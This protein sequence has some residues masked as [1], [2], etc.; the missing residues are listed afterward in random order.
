MKKNYLSLILLL[1]AL[2]FSFGQSDVVISQYI[3]TNSGTTPK[4]IEIFNISGA[5]IDFAV[6]NLEIFQGTNGAAC[7]SLINVTSGTL[8]ADEVWVIGTSNLTS[9][10][11][12][13]GTDLSGTTDYAFAF[14]GDDAL[15][16]EL[17]G[18]VQDMFGIC[19]AD[20]GAAWTGGGVSTANNNLQIQNGICDGDTDGWTDPSSRFDQI[21]DGS[22]MTGF[23]N[24]PASCSTTNTTVQFTST[25]STLPEGGLFIDVCASITNPS[26]TV[27]TTVDITLDG[28]STATNGT[29][30][31]DGAGTPAA[32]VFPQTLTF[33]VGSSADQCLTIYISNDDLLIEGNE[34]VVL[35]LTNPT[36]GDAAALG[37]DTQ[38]VLTITDNDAA[39]PADV[40]ITEIM[41][42]SAGADDE[43]IEICNVSG[44][45]QVLNSYT[46]DYNGSPIF[47]FPATGVII[48][49]GSCITVSLGSNGDGT[50]NNLCPFTPDYGIDAFTNNTNNLSNASGTLSLVASDGI[51]TIDNV[52][53]DDGDGADNTGESLHIVDTSVD[54]SVTNTNWWEVL[55]GGS[56]GVN[57]LISPCT[58]PGPEI[59]VEGTTANFPDIADGDT[60]PAPFDGT[61]FGNVP[62][63]G[64]STNTFRIENFG[65]TQNLTITSVTVLSGD[66]GD[67]SI[68]ALP[69]SPIAPA[70]P[71]G[72]SNFDIEFSPTTIGV[73]TAVIQI[74]SNDADEDP[75]TFTVE[76]NAEC[77]ANTITISP[78]SGP[79][80]TVVT[81][82]GTNLSTATASFNGL[83][84]SVNNI[85]A[86]LMEVTVPPGAISGN[87]EI[88]DDLGCPGSTPF[89]IISSQ[90]SSCEGSSGTTPTDLFISEVTDANTGG[91]TY[92]EIFNGTGVA[93]NLDNYSIQFFNNGNATQNGGLINLNNVNLASGST[94]IVGVSAGSTCTGITGSDGSLADQT[95]F[96]GVNFG[97]N[98]DD[99]I[100]LY[101]GTTHVDSW[102]TYLSNT[103]ADTLGIGSEGVVFTRNNN[104]PNLP[105]TTFNITDWSYVD[106]ASCADN[107]YS[108][109]G[110]YDF[111]TGTPPT[112]N[113]ITCTTTA[114]NEVTISVSATEGFV[115]GNALAYFW[116][117][118]DPL[119]A[120]L[121][122]QAINNGGIYTTNPSSPN[123]IISN[124]NSVLDF[125]FYC[126]VRE[127]NATCYSASNAIQIT[128]GT[129]TWDGTNWIWNDST[130]IDTMPTTMSN[131][132]IDGDYDTAVG[133]IQTSFEACDCV[134]NTSYELNIRNNTY[135]LVEND[136][137]VNGNV[138]LETDGAFVQINDTASVSGDVL[139]D[140]TK[141]SV[142]KETAPLASHLEY[143]Y[144]S[145]PVNGELISDGLFEAN[146]NRIFSFDGQN[147]RDSTRETNNN[148]ATLLGQD[149]IDD[150]ANDWQF[151][152]GAT[153]MLPGVGYASTH[154]PIG[155]IGPNQYIYTFEGPFN[156]GIYNIPI[157][158]NDAELNDNN[159][160]FI[161]NPYPS[162]IDADLF[163]AANASVDQTIGATNGA[164]FFWS[165]N[166]AADGNTNGNENLNYAQSDYAIINGS[167][168]TA[169]GD[170][171][172]PTRFIPSGQGFFVSMDDGV[173]ASVHSGF[174]MTTN[175]V[176]NNSMR[177]T[178]NNNQFFRTAQ[179]NKLWLNLTSDNGVFNQVLVAYVDGAT[180]G[181]DGMYYD[182][183]K[184]LS[185][186]LYSGIYTTLDSSNDK[187]FAI[188][189]KNPNS[190]NIDEVIPLGFSTSIEEA[191]IYTISIYTTEGDF[192][193]ENDIFIIDYDL[194]IIHNLKTADYNFTANKGE[195][196]NRFEI[197]FTSEALSVNDNT[198]TSNDLII[199][200]LN[201]GEVQ[202][203]VNASYIIENVEILDVLG[204]RIYNLVG[205]NSIEVYNLSKL[206]K[207]AYIAR[208]T[209]SNG[210]VI[211]K[212]AIK[213]Q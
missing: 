22:T 202:I 82:S 7:N 119:N 108:D 213:Q 188:Q 94:Y 104:A 165:H 79:I 143:T 152:N 175:V 149:D 207:A 166:T 169:G 29:D 51:T 57:S 24:A 141:I 148:D 43:W 154:D 129:A 187:K 103:W 142:E 206:S 197:V 16:V 136:L 132:I 204:R 46:I 20:P 122:W 160:N 2:N 32:I 49:D 124:P 199:T 113:S 3:E 128:Y 47:T 151:V 106:W 73:K 56:P 131:V 173:T 209:L 88:I 147:F 58:P 139:T 13:N 45:T 178:G 116:Y 174:V 11:T 126:E 42:N 89:A 114:C 21:A 115:T 181:D 31:D 84:A 98:S 164:I 182:A 170:G 30:Y 8:A 33:P 153:V 93:V 190:L 171:V 1:F 23:G 69:S 61:D 77:V 91:L 10:A 201:N 85:S 168:Q 59:N 15:R 66:V 193:A 118:F 81:V 38:H 172:V 176:F 4:G 161:G 78:N 156:N 70:D 39:F 26:T 195:F 120:G 41:Y 189:G 96:G 60:T 71:N 53:Y 14:N 110:N 17:G 25:T 105:D 12:T 155:F 80:N 205:N 6:N 83:A 37:I 101:D 67:F 48:L 109:I 163:L 72:F 196:N 183:H 112:V 100:R 117:A 86:T 127:D 27:A 192:M 74:I 145:S 150:D 55:N 63:F 130:P 9:Y 95:G 162:A 34:T 111:S 200:E 125:Q 144:W 177:V 208:V 40:V 19:G 137:I 102:G 203:K 64:T 186:D 138:V 121:G 44:S 28:A 180:D 135:V 159:W 5:P 90:I 99:H 210:Q 107:D 134:V 62:V 123:L 50:Y 97:V 191:T 179:Y 158:R 36:G 146:A 212:K 87:L 184:N 18:I 133:G 75:Y 65:G 185:T 35:N 76:G 198:L 140:K 92:I 167:G 68:S 211:S 54:N 52:V 157:Y 194:N